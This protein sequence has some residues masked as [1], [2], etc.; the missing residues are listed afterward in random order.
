MKFQQ[1]E[2]EK[3]SAIYINYSVNSLPGKCLILFNQMKN[4][5]RG[6]FGPENLFGG[7]T[8]ERVVLMF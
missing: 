2:K 5:G 3:K 8:E 6:F 4:T 1:A 7:E